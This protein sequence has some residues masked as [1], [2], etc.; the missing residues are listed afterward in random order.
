MPQKKN[1]DIAELA[2]GK[3][4]R[5]YGHLIALLTIMKGLPLAY[6]RDMQEDKQ[7]L[8]DTVDTILSTLMVMTGL[9][10]SLQIK[11]AKMEH[12][13]KQGY[14]LATDLAD[15]LVRRGEP[16]RSA[17][18]IVGKLVN[19]AVEHNKTFH[20]LSLQE[21]KHFSP[22]FN[23]DVYTINIASSI[24]ARNVPGGTAPN[25]VHQALALAKKITNGTEAE[26]KK[27]S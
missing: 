26:I 27:L 1:P 4:G 9:I 2:R 7:G 20:E 3:T 8:F 15:F 12:A 5:V 16:F 22:L 11:P 25:Q 13:V 14:L 24:A 23:Q 10:D 17:H 21:Y 18:E 6:N 19:Y